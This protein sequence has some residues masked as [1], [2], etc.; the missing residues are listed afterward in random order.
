MANI[1]SC[2]SDVLSEVPYSYAYPNDMLNQDVQEMSYSEQTHIDTNS[3]APNDLLILSLVEQMTDQVANL[4]KENQ[5]NKMVN[6]SLS[7][8]L[9]RYKERVTIF[10]QR[11]NVDLNK[12]E[13]LI[14]SQMD[15]LIRNKNATLE[16][17]KQEINTLK[18]TLS[19]NIKE[20]ESLSTTLNVFKTKSK[21][22][23]F[24]YIDKE[25]VLEKQNKELENIIYHAVISVIDDEETLILEEES[26]SKM[27]EKQNDLISKE[28]KEIMHI[29]MNSV[30]ILDVKKSCVNEC[31]KCLEL[32]AK[33][34]EKKDFIEK[35][36]QEKDTV[37]KNL[38]DRIKSLMEKEGVENVKKDIDEIETINIELE[39][40]VEKLLSENENLRKE[41]EHLKSIFKDQFDSSKQTRVRSKE[42]SNFL[43]AQINAKSVKNS[44]LNAQLQEKVF[45]IAALKNE[46]RKLK[47]NNVV[48]TA[49]SKPIGTTIT[50]GMF[51]RNLEPLPP[52]LLNNRE[53]HMDYLKHTQEQTAFL[54]EIIKQGVN[55]STSASRSKPSGNTKNNRISQ[56][57]GSN[58]TNKVEDQSR[59][60]KSRMNKKNRVDKSKCHTYIMQSMLNVNSVSE[61]ISNTHVKHSVS[62][63]KFES[64]CAICK[65]CLFDANHAMCLIEHVNDVNLEASGRIFIIVGN[66]CPLTRITSN[67]IVPPKEST[68]APVATPTSDILVYSRRPKAS[69]SVGT[70]RFGNDHIAKIIGYDDYQIGNVIISRVYY[71]EGLGHNLFSVGQFCDSDIEVAF[72]KHT[73]SFVT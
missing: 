17:F 28:K 56:S 35:E 22:K 73:A 50:P 55:C 54:R 37:I 59:S 5:I 68:I 70:V 51:K 13:K 3:S 30:D 47:E 60:V 57:S 34:F 33:L 38:K 63:A 4:D 24:K 27:L 67:K 16:A 2:D 48:D 29:A 31:C 41:R 44:N 66:M 40:S 15:D 23:E 58:K 21:E 71:V 14:D 36:S 11:Q 64:L 43:I 25:I 26:R 49:V 20:K 62:N 52:K 19:K 53:A 9:E 8:E 6:E 45:A 18:E 10:E 72:R 69:R 7:T 32:E 1:S 39:H 61:P 42:H 12:R 65:K 46:L